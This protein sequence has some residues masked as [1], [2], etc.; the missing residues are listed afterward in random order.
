MIKLKDAAYLRL[1]NARTTPAIILKDIHGRSLPEK[2]IAG[3]L[4]FELGQDASMRKFVKQRTVK[5]ISAMQTY[6][7]LW[8]AHLPLKRL[9]QKYF[10]LVV[11]KA[12]PGLQVAAV[13]DDQLKALESVHCRCLRRI[14]NIKAAYV[15]R[16]SNNSVRKKAK[17]PTLHSFVRRLQYEF[18]RTIITLPDLHPLRMVLFEP[19]TELE[20]RK[21]E[22]PQSRTYELKIAKGRPRKTWYSILVPPLLRRFSY[23][24]IMTVAEDINRWNAA[25][26]CLCSVPEQ[27][28]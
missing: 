9:I 20:Q 14:L 25:V 15:S 12:M 21:P 1:G 17:V 4:G 2:E 6:R 27:P 7:Y 11:S 23:Q 24:H 5:M 19:F 13:T 8:R 26:S 16:V 3:T 22:I 10:A 18:L 28:Q